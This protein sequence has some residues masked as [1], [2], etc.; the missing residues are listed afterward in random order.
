[1][2]RMH[3]DEADIDPALVRRLLREQFPTWAG[4]PT[5][6]V[7]SPGTVNAIYRLGAEMC[8]RLPRTPGAVRD[9]QRERA[10]LPRLAPRLPLPIPVPL[11][12]GRPS[13]GYPWPWAVYRWLD[14]EPVPPQGLADGRGAAADL[15]AFL[16]ALHALDPAGGPPGRGAPLS[17]REAETRAALA[18]LRGTM[19]VDA[20]AASWRASLDAPPWP[21]PPVWTHG[22]LLPTNLLTAGGR[23]AAVLDFGTA[24]VG[25]PACDLIPAWSVLPAGA[26]E[27]FRNAVAVDEATWL[28]GRGWALTIALVIIPYYAVTNPSFVAMARHMVAAVLADG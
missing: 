27:A 13:D 16:G 3:P 8:V 22:D 18:A 5:A 24:G 14:G 1:M 11:A 17:S 10:W 7:R 28:R 26:R 12:E 6:P 25:D 23:I 20:A 4:L 15:A 9:L 21:G 19:D 2:S